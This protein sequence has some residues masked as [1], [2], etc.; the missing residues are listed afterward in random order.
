[1]SVDR[2]S[3]RAAIQQVFKAHGYTYEGFDS[4]LQNA[5]ADLFVALSGDS[6]PTPLD[7]VQAISNAR[8]RWERYV[9]DCNP[10]EELDEHGRTLDQAIAS[11]VELWRALSGDSTPDTNTVEIG[12]QVMTEAQFNAARFPLLPENANPGRALSG[13]SEA[14]KPGQ[15][16]VHCVR[17]EFNIP[18][19]E[20]SEDCAAAP[21]RG[22]HEGIAPVEARPSGWSLHVSGCPRGH[23]FAIGNEIVDSACTCPKFRAALSGGGDNEAPA[24]VPDNPCTCDPRYGFHWTPNPDCA[25]NKRPAAPSG[26]TER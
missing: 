22:P 17:C 10:I 18:W 13:D 19:S 7:L 21:D 5:L 6:E 20:F 4:S 16:M 25:R 24:T 15:L 12:A 3:A 14:P 1:M 26:E 8:H 11:R 9:A 23:P 2:E